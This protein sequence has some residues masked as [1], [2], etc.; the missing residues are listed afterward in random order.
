MGRKDISGT[1]VDYSETDIS[2][3]VGVIA[4]RTEQVDIVP[5][6]S[7]EFANADGKLKDASGNSVSNSESFGIV[8]LGIGFVFSHQVSIKTAVAIPF[9]LNGASTTFGVTLA[10]NFGA[11]R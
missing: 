11:A 10:V 8:G 6:G 3:G 5:T 4:T 2:L 7:I 1:G 9:G